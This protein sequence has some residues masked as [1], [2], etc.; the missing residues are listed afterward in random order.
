M[1]VLFPIFFYVKY[2]LQG[3][4]YLKKGLQEIADDYKLKRVGLQHQ[5]GSDALLTR[6]VFFKVKE[7][8]Y[9]KEDITKHAVKLYGIECKIDDD[10]IIL[11]YINL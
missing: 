2:L 9:Q 10:K 3:S 4:K 5:A 6:S 8:F 11:G 7:M 1:S